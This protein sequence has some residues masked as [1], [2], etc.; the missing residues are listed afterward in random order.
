MTK[1]TH[2]SARQ[3]KRVCD[4]AKIVECRLKFFLSQKP[5]LPWSPTPC[6]RLARKSSGIIRGPSPLQRESV[7]LNPLIGSRDNGSIQFMVQV[8]ASP[9]SHPR[10][11]KLLNAR[12]VSS[13]G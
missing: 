6:A 11:V 9:S 3:A 1:S 10:P 4:V 13:N 2:L 12:L 7:Q 8:L 5:A